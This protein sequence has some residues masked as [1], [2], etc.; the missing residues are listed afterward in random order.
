MACTALDRN[1]GLCSAAEARYTLAESGRARGG[2]LNRSCG[3]M[4]EDA[5]DRNGPGCALG[6]E[7]PL[8]EYP[9]RADPAE[10]IGYAALGSSDERLI[11]AGTAIDLAGSRVGAPEVGP[12]TCNFAD[13]GTARFATRHPP[14]SRG[15]V[16]VS[17]TCHEVSLRCHRVSQKCHRGVTEVSRGCHGGVTTRKIKAGAHRVASI[18]AKRRYASMT[19]AVM[20]RM[21]ERR[22]NRFVGPAKTSV[23]RAR[24]S[25][26][27]TTTHETAHSKSARRTHGI[28]DDTL[29]AHPRPFRGTCYLAQRESQEGR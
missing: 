18:A 27:E 24:T 2:L 4:G 6:D 3:S 19:G 20:E 5:A 10:P 16:N 7:E 9:R 29:S 25:F 17:V 15:C 1:A 28:H 12:G 21:M 8:L 26:D 23:S 13:L 22:R 14:A 11:C